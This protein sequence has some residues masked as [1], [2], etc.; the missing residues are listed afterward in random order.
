MID[1]KKHKQFL[2]FVFT[3]GIAAV[4]NFTS[5]MLVAEWVGYDAAIVIGY[6]LGMLIAFLFGRLWVFKG[7]KHSVNKS[8]YWFVLFNLLGMLQTYLVSIALYYYV[9]PF[10]GW[11]FYPADIAHFIGICFP[12]FVNFFAHKYVSFSR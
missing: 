4:A 3:S 2:L 7:S 11:Q 1:V 12:V 8:L 10:V 9:F 6:L 5:R